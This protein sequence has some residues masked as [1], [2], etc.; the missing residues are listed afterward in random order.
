MA[1]FDVQVLTTAPALVSAFRDLALRQLPFATA[2]ALTVLAQ[3]ARDE[4]RADLPSRFTLRNERVR[5]GVTINPARKSDGLKR[6]ASEVGTRDQFMVVHEAGGWRRSRSG[7]HVAVPTRMVTR[8][9]TKTGKVPRPLKPRTLRAKGARVVDGRLLL[10]PKRRRGRG[11]ALAIAY[12]LHRRV[13]I[14]ARWGFV[15]TA[16]DVVRRRYA[17]IFRRELV[18]A[19]RAS[20]AR[21][22][23]SAPSR[24]QFTAFD[25]S[26]LVR[27]LRRAR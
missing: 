21:G 15:A 9:R 7:G 25:A 3:E 6:M 24:A 10:P 13:H 23:Q 17:R 16:V 2:K 26:A 22:D 18:R 4:I 12:T 11:R 27:S 5:R 20:K 1:R 19:M 14:D 8:R